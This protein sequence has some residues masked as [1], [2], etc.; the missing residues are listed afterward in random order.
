M[1]L[2]CLCLPSTPRPLHPEDAQ[3]AAFLTLT[4][5]RARLTRSPS[6][7]CQQAAKPQSTPGIN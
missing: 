4:M 2:K 5:S 7:S 3:P 1:G 6:R